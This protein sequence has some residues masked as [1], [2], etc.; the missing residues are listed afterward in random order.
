MISNKLT[1]IQVFNKNIVS[2]TKGF[3]IIHFLY[4]F[5]IILKKY[6]INK[7]FSNYLNRTLSFNQVLN[8]DCTICLEKIVDEVSLLCNHSFCAKCISIYYCNF[9]SKKVEIICPNCRKKSEIFKFKFK[10]NHTNKIYHNF[11]KNYN[12]IVIKTN[13]SWFCSCNYKENTGSFK[14][15][16]RRCLLLDFLLDLIILIIPE[17]KDNDILTFIG[18]LCLHLTFILLLTFSLF[19]LLTRK[20]Q[21]IKMIKNLKSTFKY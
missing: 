3:A 6:F 14:Y 18:N 20:Y 15:P 21:I 12:K 16:Q 2:F 4:F 10:R 11:L 7:R 1:Y 19:I 17:I 5:A 8:K 13:K 9:E